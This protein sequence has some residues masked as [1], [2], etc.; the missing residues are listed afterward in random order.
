MQQPKPGH[1]TAALRNIYHV[2][3]PVKM[4]DAVGFVA[5]Q[6]RDVLHDCPWVGWMNVNGLRAL[7]ASSR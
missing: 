4:A 1:P 3:K 5:E 6:R 2:T 7:I